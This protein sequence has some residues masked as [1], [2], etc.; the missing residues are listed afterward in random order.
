[1]D[2]R[3]TEAEAKKIIKTMKAISRSKYAIEAIKQY[4]P[5]T[6]RILENYLN[7]LNGSIKELE[8]K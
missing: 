7:Q 3:T 5:E 8:K 6:T 1:M 4:L 2:S